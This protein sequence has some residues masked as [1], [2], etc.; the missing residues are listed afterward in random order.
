MAA[1]LGIER[2]LAG[3]PVL[4]P[5]IRSMSTIFVDRERAAGLSGVYTGAAGIRR[6]PSDTTQEGLVAG[7]RPGQGTLAKRCA[8]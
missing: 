4:G 5:L 3:W 6:V 7:Q 1:L 2:D 8:G